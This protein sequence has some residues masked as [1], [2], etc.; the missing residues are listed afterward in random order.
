MFRSVDTR[1]II[2]A[3][4]VWVPSFLD[5]LLERSPRF[6]RKGLGCREPCE[7]TREQTLT[8]TLD[9]EKLPSTMHGFAAYFEAVLYK[10]VTL[11][12]VPGTHTPK[13]QSWFPMFF[14]LVTPVRL[15]PGSRVA[16]S[17][18]RLSSPSQVCPP[19]AFSLSAF[20][21]LLQ[22][23]ITLTCRMCRCQPSL[24]GPRTVLALH[25]EQRYILARYPQT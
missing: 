1:A 18:W 4:T 17:I 22:V 21:S 8:F 16:M 24:F 10:D 3:A 5:P 25:I 9:P 15:E 23:P 12:T 14:P 19:S 6:K 13:M 20:C 2:S 11:S 7:R